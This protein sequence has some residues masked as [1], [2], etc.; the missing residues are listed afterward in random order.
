MTCIIQRFVGI[1]YYEIDCND[2]AT[3]AISDY[4]QV[5]IGQFDCSDKSLRDSE[6]INKK[7]YLSRDL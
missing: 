6:C 5:T 7:V 1:S 2:L 4:F 3:V